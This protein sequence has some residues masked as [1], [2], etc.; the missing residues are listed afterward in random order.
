MDE[1]NYVVSIVSMP[2]RVESVSKQPGIARSVV[3]QSLYALQKLEGTVFLKHIENG[4][5]KKIY[6]K[7]NQ[8]N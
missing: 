6:V 4:M 2:E 5:P 8:K 1:S 7:K 3:I